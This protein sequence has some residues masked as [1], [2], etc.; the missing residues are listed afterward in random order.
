[1]RSKTYVNR[2]VMD[3]QYGTMSM[4]DSGYGNRTV[5]ASDLRQGLWC[6]QITGTGG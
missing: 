2:T 4:T 6:T 1:M 5:I 3:I